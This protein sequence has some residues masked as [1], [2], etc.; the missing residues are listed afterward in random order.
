[1]WQEALNKFIQKYKKNKN[2]EAILLVGSYAVNNE[3]KYSDIDV[4]IIMNNNIKYRK[5]GNKR[6]DNYLIEYFVNPLYKVPAYIK[7]DKRGHGGP[8]ANMIINCKVLYDKNGI[9]PKL[10][11]QAK[12]ALS[13]KNK[14]DNLKYYAAWCAYDDYQAAKYHNDM[15]YYLCL[16]YLLEAY[17]YNNDYQIPPELKYERFF[18]DEEYRKKYNFHKFPSNEFNILAINCF[19]KPNKNNLKKLY[20]Y[21][22]QDGNFDINNFELKNKL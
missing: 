8:M 1:M 5:R 12:K 4:Y 16:K 13:K 6:I 9:I 14:K 20:E 7:E 19:N 21:V 22:I 11:K 15:Q 2:V 17:L 3:D 10:K 18:K